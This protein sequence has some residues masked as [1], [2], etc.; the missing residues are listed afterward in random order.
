MEKRRT[1]FFSVSLDLSEGR[2]FKTNTLDVT[3]KG[4]FISG[5]LDVQKGDRLHIVIHELTDRS[6]IECRVI[7][8]LPWGENIKHPAGFGVL[9][10]HIKSQQR[11]ELI[12]LIGKKT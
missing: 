6:Y 7:W 2:R 1:A 8:V 10:T 9:F 5:V 12:S 4:C 11:E 3:D